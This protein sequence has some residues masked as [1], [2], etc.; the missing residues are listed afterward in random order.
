[1]S[2]RRKLILFSTLTGVLLAFVL[3]VF[4]RLEL[5][6]YDARVGQ[7]RSIRGNLTPSKASQMLGFSETTR[8]EMPEFGIGEERETYR[9]VKERAHS[10]WVDPHLGWSF[11]PEE[12]RT[13]PPPFKP[14]YDGS[15]RRVEL[16]D[17]NGLS[18]ALR[19]YAEQQGVEPQSVVVGDNWVQ[20]GEEKISRWLPVDFPSHND[21]SYLEPPSLHLLFDKQGGAQKSSQEIILGRLTGNAVMLVNHT[22]EAR[23]RTSTPIGDL[24]SHQ[25]TYS[26][27]DTLL[28]GWRL[29]ESPPALSAVLAILLCSA[30]SWWAVRSGSFLAAILSWA[31]FSYLY[32]VLAVRLF[33]WGYSI[34][35]VPVVAG[36]LIAIAIVA[37]VL[38]VRAFRLMKQLVGEE[39]AADAARGEIDLGGQERTVTILFTNL[40]KEIQA[41]EQVDPEESIRARNRYAATL[42]RGVRHNQGRILDYQGDFQMAGFCVEKVD[43]DHALNAVKAGLELCR[44]LREQ[45]PNEKI[46]C[47]VCTG[48]A[49]VGYVGAPSSKELAAI[50]DTTNVAARLLGAAMK[51]G[52]PVLIASTTFDLCS[53]DLEA[54]KLPAVSLKG[55]TSDV[56]VYSVE[57]IK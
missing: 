13:E 37:A 12:L 2:F 51:Q 11:V 47:G 50:G 39:R 23:S 56:E 53:E 14:D 25:I 20:V 9:L 43:P 27:L 45:Y 24:E 1:M 41:L 31:A 8:T 3:P 57:G 52:V 54:E 19:L 55:K 48:P 35:V 22:Q 49:A 30:L 44:T 32:W 42:T 7:V 16:A 26:A 28:S 40:P 15:V 6:A 29:Q 36:S 10:L 17:E 5:V 38:Q 21:N 4:V 18:P 33:A 34:P 46:H